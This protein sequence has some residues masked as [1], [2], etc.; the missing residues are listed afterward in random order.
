M[1]AGNSIND[2]LEQLDAVIARARRDNSRL[3]YF[4]VLY[5]NVTQKVKEGIE[6][7]RF[8]DGARMERLDVIFASRYLDALESHRRGERAS[9][10]WS[11]SFKAAENWHPL[12][13]QHLLL[14]I[15]AHINLDLG[16]AAA[17][18]A[19]HAQLPALRRDFDEIN[20]ILCAMLDDVQNRLARVSR[21]MTVLDRAGCRTDEALMNFSINRA[22]EASWRLAEK[23]APLSDEEREREIRELDR[24]IEILA[25]LIQYPGIPL[26]IANFFVRLTETR[27][28]GKVIDILT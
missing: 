21:W 22:R 20:N 15:N 26:R 5:R 14:G 4:A 3:G 18:T 19:P 10:C 1:P 6:A 17:L 23:L 8:E 12:V 11:A 9:K 24:W 28:V 25:R 27:N 13:L 16:V 7:G 2:V